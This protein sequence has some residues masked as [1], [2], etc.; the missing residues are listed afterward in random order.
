VIN[1]GGEDRRCTDVDT[2]NFDQETLDKD[3]PISEAAT[4]ALDDSDKSCRTNSAHLTLKMHHGASFSQIEAPLLLRSGTTIAT[5]KRRAS[6]S[7]DPA[8]GDKHQFTCD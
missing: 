7:N 2:F 1:T 4:A 6:G 8:P 3:R 5:P